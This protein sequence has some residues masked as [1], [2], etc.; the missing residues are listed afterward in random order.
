[1]EWLSTF[2]IMLICVVSTA[3]HIIY[4]QPSV[5]MDAKSVSIAA[6]VLSKFAEG[7]YH[8]PPKSKQSHLVPTTPCLTDG[9]LSMWHKSNFPLKSAVPR[10][11]KSRIYIMRIVSKFA[12]WGTDVKIASMA[13]FMKGKRLTRRRGRRTRKILKTLTRL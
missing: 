13:I 5:V 8:S 9:I 6:S 2:G 10:I 7:V 12:Y 3:A 4:T 11:E 1:M